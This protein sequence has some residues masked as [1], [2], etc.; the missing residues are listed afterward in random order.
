L[1]AVLTRM[2]KPQV[3]RFPSQ[4]AEVISKLTPVHKAE[5]YSFGTLPADLPGDRVKELT[6]IIKDLWHESET[7]PIYEGRIGASPREMQ[8]V[9]LATVGS[10]R[11]T[12]VSPLVALE[13]ITELC[14]HSGLYDFLRQ[15]VQPGGYHDHRGLI[16]VVRDRLMD[17][18][19]DEVRSALGLIEESEYQRIFDRYVIHITHWTSKEKVRNPQTGRMEDADESL[20]REVEATLEAAG[21][22]EDFRQGLIAKIGAWAIDHR[23]EKP[24]P[25]KIFPDLLKKLRDAYYERHKKV[26][27]RGVLELMAVLVGQDSSLNAD[28]LARA[29][30][31]ETARASWSAR[32]SA[33]ATADPGPAARHGSVDGTCVFSGMVRILGPCERSGS[34]WP[35]SWRWG[36]RPGPMSASAPT[37]RT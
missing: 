5:L 22:A 15:D 11:T 36:D 27:G 18:I 33:R 17:R 24:V 3:D 34:R 6:P 29:Q 2:R 16:D 23:G 32:W 12:F 4:A 14:K 21:R 7:Y 1:W 35:C 37:S 25:G 9:I 13:E 20:M 10:T 19:D 28:A 26:I 8:S 30:N 31:A